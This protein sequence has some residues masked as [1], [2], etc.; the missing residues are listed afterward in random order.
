MS[1]RPTANMLAPLY[2]VIVYRDHFP[3]E[4]TITDRPFDI[5][6]RLAFRLA[7]RS[8]VTQVVIRE[9]GMD[10][11]VV[12]YVDRFEKAKGE[13]TELFSLLALLCVEIAEVSGLNPTIQNFVADIEVAYLEC[14]V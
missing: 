13:P 6:V 14:E 2:D 11:Q 9:V 7:A 4:Q 12:N 8:C 5:A 3:T 1:C 10:I